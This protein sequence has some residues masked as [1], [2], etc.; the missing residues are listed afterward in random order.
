M[1]T[2]PPLVAGWKKSE[3]K[4][5]NISWPIW[6]TSV[7]AVPRAVKTYQQRANTR[8]MA[9]KV[10]EITDFFLSAASNGKD[11]NTIPR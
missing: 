6:T 5:E 1:R 2:T 9:M 3:K 11:K 8:K 4:D 10:D 7:T